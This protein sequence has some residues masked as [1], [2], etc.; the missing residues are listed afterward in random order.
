[1]EEPVSTRHSGE[2]PL[3]LQRD[4][5]DVTQ[6]RK[7]DVLPSTRSAAPVR[8]EKDLPLAI[9]PASLSSQLAALRRRRVNRILV[10][11][12]RRHERSYREPASCLMVVAALFTL[13]LTSFSS[14]AGAAY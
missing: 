12:K 2:T 8:P 10:M 14:S 7:A 1:M 6:K 9:P 4:N 13:L 3:V 5:E 11:R